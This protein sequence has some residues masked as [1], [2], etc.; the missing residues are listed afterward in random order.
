MKLLPRFVMLLETAA[1]V[2]PSN[3]LSLLVM[4]GVSFLV[5]ALRF[6]TQGYYRFFFSSK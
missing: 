4:E 5:L 3:L 6:L 2:G 1:L